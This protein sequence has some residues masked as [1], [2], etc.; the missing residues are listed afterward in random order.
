MTRPRRKP[1]PGKGRGGA[2]FGFLLPAPPLAC[3]GLCPP[4]A[5]AGL[6]VKN[7]SG[8]SGNGKGRGTAAGGRGLEAPLAQQAGPRLDQHS[9]PPGGGHVRRPACEAAGPAPFVATPGGPLLEKGRA[10]PGAVSLACAQLGA[11]VPRGRKCPPRRDV[12]PGAALTGLLCSLCGGSLEVR[13]GCRTGQTAPGNTAPSGRG[14]LRV[15]VFL[16][17]FIEVPCA[18]RKV[19]VPEVYG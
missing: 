14:Q 19:P 16:N 12:P 18:N 13:V 5:E 2:A 9:R 8:A 7:S 3:Q 4:P 15:W 17:N 6:R 1:Q 11:S 10:W